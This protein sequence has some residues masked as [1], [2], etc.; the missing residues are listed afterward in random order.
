MK[1]NLPARYEHSLAANLTLA[2]TL[3]FCI[4]PRGR[5]W[6]NKNWKNVGD[7][8]FKYSCP[9]AKKLFPELDIVLKQPVTG[10][11]FDFALS[12]ARTEAKEIRNVIFHN[13]DG[14]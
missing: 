5:G 1:L 10:I 13:A 6:L 8:N 2:A 14:I 3:N 12:S 4:L 11:I 7:F 9:F